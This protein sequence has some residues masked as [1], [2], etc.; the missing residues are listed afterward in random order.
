VADI[1]IKFA[2]EENVSDE[3]RKAAAG[4]DELAQSLDK[5]TTAAKKN[6][7]ATDGAGKGVDRLAAF[8]T[9]ANQALEIAGKV[10]GVA[11]RAAEALGDYVKEGALEAIAAEKAQR[12]L[13]AA[14]GGGTERITAMTSALQRR[15]GADADAMN[16]QA[17]TLASMGLTT[18]QIERAIPALRAYSEVTG[19][20]ASRA[21]MTLG[22]A[23]EE[24][25]RREDREPLDVHPGGG[26]GN[27]NFRRV[28][29]APDAQPRGV[30]GGARLERHR[31]RQAQGLARRP[32]SGRPRS[33]GERRGYRPAPRRRAR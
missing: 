23:F 11:S 28:R 30:P 6:E 2:A 20:D 17:A 19:K 8:V 10:W 29:R 21:V 3:A 26:R 4:T 9:G 1:K 14:L 27:A 31:I 33:D 12:Q 32:R 7:S 24:G 18:E 15:T 5:S 13:T 16:Q 25:G 22:K